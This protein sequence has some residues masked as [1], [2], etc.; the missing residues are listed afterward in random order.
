MYAQLIDNLG[1][2]LTPVE[3]KVRD[4]VFW[5]V[6]E[7]EFATLGLLGISDILKNT[8]WTPAFLT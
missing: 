7:F 4:V 3:T 8:W 5:V 2:A 6:A 1:T